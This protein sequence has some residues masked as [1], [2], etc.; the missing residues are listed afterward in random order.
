MMLQDL[1]SLEA[2][3]SN[4][5]LLDD[6]PELEWLAKRKG[7]ITGSRI[8]S[9]WRPGRDKAT[10]TQQG[11]QYLAGVIAERL[12]SERPPVTSY[13]TAWG[14]EHEALAIE[15]YRAQMSERGELDGEIDASP[16]NFFEFEQW[17]GS[18]PDALVGSVGTLEVKCPYNPVNHIQTLLKCK[19]PT[20]H[21]TPYLEQCH[22]H[23]L[24]TGREWCDFVSF[25]ARQP[26]DSPGRLCVIRVN[27][28][29]TVLDHLTS[30]LTLAIAHVET[31]LEQIRN[32]S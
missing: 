11:Y 21:S 10:F 4:E 27:R 14:T 22:A 9:I 3:E 32:Q 26:I 20:G 29:E 24:C 25:D 30:R 6:T 2:F 19:V 8:G 7:R 12:G 28:D 23:L 5:T 17:A 13:T 18:T 16:F 15:A 1:A 31:C